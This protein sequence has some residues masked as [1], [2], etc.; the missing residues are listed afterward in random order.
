MKSYHQ[1]ILITL[2]IATL[3]FSG[4]SRSMEYRTELGKDEQIQSGDPVTIDGQEAG[5]VKG[6]TYTAEGTPIASLSI[7]GGDLA[8]QTLRVGL[9]RV[10][11]DGQVKLSSKG[12]QP[13]SEPLR[14]GS[15]IPSQNAL[16]TVLTQFASGST[17]IAIAVG[18][19]VLLILLFFVK[20]LFN[21]GAAVITLILAGM[22]AWFITPYVAPFVAKAYETAPTPVET[23]QSAPQAEPA[24][25]DASEANEKSLDGMLSRVHSEVKKVTVKRPDPEVAAF[26]GI[27]VIAFL[28][29]SVLVGKVFR[30]FKRL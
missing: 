25:H 1:P 9:V 2:A 30:H 14:P 4:C 11:A 21:I 13:N 15:T 20:R 3:A 18:I 26:I 22:A 27:F 17:A 29:W 24:Q 6:I 16:T 12:V 8:E 5:K 19:A 7:K 23:I 10:P 28:I